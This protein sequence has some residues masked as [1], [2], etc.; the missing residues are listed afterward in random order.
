[1]KTPILTFLEERKS[2]LENQAE[3]LLHVAQQSQES[4]LEI[5]THSQKLFEN[6]VRQNELAKIM[7]FV[8]SSNR[9]VA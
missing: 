2:E 5:I 4:S 9:A 8:I 1:M 7:H 3:N 6:S